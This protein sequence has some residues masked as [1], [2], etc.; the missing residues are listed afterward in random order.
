MFFRC[1]HENGKDELRGEEHL[2]KEPSH[3][4]SASAQLSEDIHGPGEKS[5]YDTSS[6]NAAQDLRNDNNGPAE[7][8]K[9][10]NKTHSECYL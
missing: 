9:G 2:D 6:C 7:P 3:D 4:G 10:A 8:G 1:Q 5:R